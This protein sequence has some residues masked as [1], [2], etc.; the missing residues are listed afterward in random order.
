[1]IWPILIKAYGFC[2]FYHMSRFIYKFA[3]LT[4]CACLLV[5]SQFFLQI[6]AWS[7]ML[8][9]YAQDSSL[10]LAVRDTFSGERPC[11][12]CTA[13][14]STRESE[15]ES[16]TA[17]QRAEDLRL[18]LCPTEQIG[19]GT[20]SADLKYSSAALLGPAAGLASVPV[21]PPKRTSV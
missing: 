10:E 17:P 18:L 6:G 2:L 12:M 11:A 21:P 5:G 20:A 3:L 19:Y 8:V 14:S 13:I 16:T 1:M 7:W 15:P 9:S 4:L